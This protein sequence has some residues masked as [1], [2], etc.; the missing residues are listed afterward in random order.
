[1]S[2]SRESKSNRGA[3][4]R[5][6]RSRFKVKVNSGIVNLLNE[7]NHGFARIPRIRVCRGDWEN[8]EILVGRAVPCPPRGWGYKLRGATKSFANATLKASRVSPILLRLDVLDSPFG[9][10]GRG[11]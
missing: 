6:F 4:S 3:A 8:R 9:A 1:M 5:R 11:F 2:R 7:F 10:E